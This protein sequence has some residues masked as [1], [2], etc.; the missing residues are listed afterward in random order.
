M[1]SS[2]RH[3]HLRLSQD[4]VQRSTTATLRIGYLQGAVE[5]Q[6]VFCNDAWCTLFGVPKEVRDTISRTR[7]SPMRVDSQDAPRVSSELAQAV[8]LQRPSY[9]TT[10]QYVGRGGARFL[11]REVSQLEYWGNGALRSLTTCYTLLGAVAA[12]AASIAVAVATDAAASHAIASKNVGSITPIARSH[13]GGITLP[14]AMLWGSKGEGV[15][16]T[17]AGAAAAAAPATRCDSIGSTGSVGGGSV[18]PPTTTTSAAAA[19]ASYPPPR[20]FAGLVPGAPSYGQPLQA[21]GGRPGDLS[22]G[23]LLS[24][25]SSFYFHTPQQRVYQHGGGG[26]GG[27][28]TGGSG[29]PQWLS[30]LIPGLVSQEEPLSQLVP[31]LRDLPLGDLST[32][33]P[34]TM[35]PFTV[36]PKLQQRAAAAAALAA[37]AA[38]AA[39]P[40]SKSLLCN[41]DTADYVFDV[42]VKM[43]EDGSSS[44]SSCDS[45]SCDSSS[46]DSSSC[47]SSNSSSSSSGSCGDIDLLE[48]RPFAWCDAQKQQPQ[49]QQPGWGVTA[50]PLKPTAA[51]SFSG[52]MLPLAPGLSSFSLP[53]TVA[54]GGDYDLVGDSLDGSQGDLRGMMEDSSCLAPWRWAACGAAAAVGD[55][56]VFSL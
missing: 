38:S 43:G 24:S 45:S 5:P 49:Q 53:L 52:A 35:F 32:L 27:S 54:C 29:E 11:A 37:A 42:V 28:W 40:T 39:A 3:P 48:E 46:C 55:D 16:L 18:Q 9:A 44:S 30:G 13:L 2:H 26:G 50:S 33:R 51:A 41:D 56:D 4:D 7:A 14:S 10:A 25:A 31:E 21:R 22:E 23:V 8:L 20:S 6:S 12:A 19:A 36:A 47:D 15:R 34:S 17:T 1:S